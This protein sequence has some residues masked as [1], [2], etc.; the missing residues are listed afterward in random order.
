MNMN[1]TKRRYGETASQVRTQMG[2]PGLVAATGH[3]LRPS[4]NVRFR[5]ASPQH[6][7]RLAI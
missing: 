4:A 1:E 6:G 3:I 7:F 2:I 5:A